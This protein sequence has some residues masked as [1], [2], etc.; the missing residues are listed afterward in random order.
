MD[1]SACYDKAGLRKGPWTAEEDQK[2]LDYFKQH[3][4]WNLAFVACK[5]W[6]P[7]MREEL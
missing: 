4:P 5:S 3:G 6:T 7:K 2:L 1:S